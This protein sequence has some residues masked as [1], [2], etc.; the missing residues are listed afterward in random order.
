MKRDYDMVVLGGGSAGLVAAGMSALLGAKTMMVER[1]RLGGDCTWTGCIPSKTLIGVAKIAHRTRAAN[2]GGL[3]SSTPE[4][5]F[6]RVMQHA[7]DIR[8]KVYEHADAPPHFERMGVK[9]VEASARFLDP[10]SVELADAGG[11]L[12]RITSRFFVIATGAAPADP[13]F[14]ADTLTNETIFELRSRPNH[15]VVL[16]AGPVGIEMAQAFRR[17]G[18]SVSVVA[19]GP[20]I[21]PRDEPELTGLLK[22]HL[23][24]EGISFALGNR[25]MSAE[26]AGSGIGVTLDD[27]RKIFCDAVLMATGR[28][29]NIEGLGLEN[30]GVAVSK[31]GVP[32]DHRCRT[33]QKHIYA[34]GDVTGRF[35]FTHMAEHMSKVAVTNAILRIPKFLDEAHVTWATFSDP[36]L[37]RVGASEDELRNRG[38]K[39]SVY[40]FP[41]TKID[42]AIT[43][44]ETIGI[45][46][47][48]AGKSGKI[49]GASILGAHGGE[50]I[51]EYALAMRNGMTLQQIS[52]TIHPYPTYML[53]TR[54]A[55]DQW[56]LKWLDSPLLGVIGRLFGYRGVRNGMSAI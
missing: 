46:K 19:P 12:Q 55:A 7:R 42:R 11:K 28:V 15:L 39:Y 41:F 40:R 20:N 43:E 47:V 44:G 13:G 27:G 36:E 22:K 26:Q 32:V 1:H 50:M 30:A 17:L 33:S 16:G 31:K 8:Q 53:G 2:L 18:S 49:V 25:G 35:Q 51:A 24:D 34:S 10:H 9:V 5:D 52:E 4:F 54:Q 6:E 38:A 37:A 45:I 29:P 23:E 56:N 21:L 3:A 14:A 48:L